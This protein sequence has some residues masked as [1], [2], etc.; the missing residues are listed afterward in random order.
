M[1]EVKSLTD[2]TDMNLIVKDREAWHATVHKVA[3]SQTR[4]SDWTHTGTGAYPRSLGRPSSFT[5]DLL[6]L[7]FALYS[8]SKSRDLITQTLIQKLRKE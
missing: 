3:K 5:E 4:I 2:S 7:E 8:I 1:T 6:S